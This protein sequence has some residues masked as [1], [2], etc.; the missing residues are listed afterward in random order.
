M[1]AWLKI[2]LI[3]CISVW[4]MVGRRERRYVVQI[5][6]LYCVWLMVGERENGR[7]VQIAIIFYMVGRKERRYV[8]IGCIRLE[9]KKT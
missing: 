2:P 9:P 6:W 7:N 3:S 5:G 8:H 1:F 4:L